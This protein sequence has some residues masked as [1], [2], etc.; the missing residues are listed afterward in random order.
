MVAKDSNEISNSNR[1]LFGV[2]PVLFVR[3]S[4][5]TIPRGLGTV[6]LATPC[7]TTSRSR[8]WMLPM[9][10]CVQQRFQRRLSPT[11]H[12]LLTESKRLETD[13][14]SVI[15]GIHIEQI[16]TTWMQSPCHRHKKWWR[17]GR[18]NDTERRIRM[19]LKSVDS[20]RRCSRPM[21]WLFSYERKHHCC[22]V[23]FI[24]MAKRQVRNVV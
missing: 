9:R 7:T 5:D 12:N 13:K 15:Q 22:M 21:S 14:F 19:Q 17:Q 8:L 1:T 18:R 20:S 11:P 3:L 2:H 16:N 24:Y 23:R 4:Q 10:K 6:S